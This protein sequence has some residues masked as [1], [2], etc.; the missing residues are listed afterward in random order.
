M[1][2]SLLVAFLQLLGRDMAPGHIA[3]GLLGV[4]AL[5]CQ[6]WR[7]AD[8]DV[9]LWACISLHTCL[10]GHYSGNGVGGSGEWAALGTDDLEC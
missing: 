2:I 9:L 3:Q 1:C 7:H 4:Q 10:C 6:I 5:L 8:R